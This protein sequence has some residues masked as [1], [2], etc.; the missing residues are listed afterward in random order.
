MHLPTRRTPA[1]PTPTLRVL[2]A[3]PSPSSGNAAQVVDHHFEIRLRSSELRTKLEDRAIQF[4]NVEKRLL[5]KFKDK[6]P[7][8]L[9]Q[10]DYLMDETYTSIMDM[11]TVLDVA[12]E[13]LRDAANKLACTVQL[14]VLLIRSGSRS[15]DIVG[16]MHNGEE[17]GGGLRNQ[18]FPLSSLRYRFSCSDEEFAVLRSYLSP[19]VID[20]TE[21]GWEEC[22]EV[23]GLREQRLRIQQ[24]ASFAGRHDAAVAVE[25]GQVVQGSSGPDPHADAGQGHDKAEEARGPG[26][27]E[28]RTRHAHA[29]GPRG[30]RGIRHQILGFWAWDL[31]FR[32]DASE[33][34]DAIAPRLHARLQKSTVPR[35]SAWGR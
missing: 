19:E 31:G 7:S 6:N 28:T 16:G 10:L 33:R 12:Q 29:A 5:M 9:N 34:A 8:P 26:A 17:H 24:M 21:I 18:R 32:A 14:I 22:V 4:R 35:A 11:G 13:Q 15:D 3:Q 23:S 20:G 1:T 30:R 27:G 2:L 25:P